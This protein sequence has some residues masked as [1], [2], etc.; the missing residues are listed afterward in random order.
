MTST[1]KSRFLTPSTWSLTLLK[2]PHAIDMKYA[3]LS[4]NIDLQ[5]LKN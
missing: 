2:C 4:R 1:I 5:G 3:S